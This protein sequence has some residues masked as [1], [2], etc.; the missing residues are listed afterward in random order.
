MAS[1]AFGTSVWF[2]KNVDKI[3]QLPYTFKCISCNDWGTHKQSSKY[4]V[5]NITMALICI[6]IKSNINLK[7]WWKISR[8]DFRVH[9]N[10][11]LFLYCFITFHYTKKWI[12]VHK[13]IF[14]SLL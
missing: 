12:L 10:F 3:N 7:W 2:P 8:V 5:T 1:Y 11:I 6:Y 9:S 14:S 4:K 13:S